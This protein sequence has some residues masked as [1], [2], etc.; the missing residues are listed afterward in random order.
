MDDDHY[1]IGT[2]GKFERAAGQKQNGS[3]D[4][5]FQAKSGKRESHFGWYLSALNYPAQLTSSH[6]LFKFVR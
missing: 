2:M 3:T 5:T 6:R 1:Y 4:Q